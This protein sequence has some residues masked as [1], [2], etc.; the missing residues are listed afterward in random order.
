M[1]ATCATGVCACPSGQHA[2]GQQCV[3]D[4]AIMS[5]GTSCVSCPLPANGQATCQAS[6]CG[7]SCTPGFRPSGNTCV[8]V[9]EC[10]TG[11]GGCSANASC[12]NT[13]GARTCACRNG[14]TGDGVTCTDVD[15]CATSNGGCSADAT[16][17]NTPGA[18]T[19]ACRSGFTGDGL[20]C[21]DVN[22]C[23][24]NN[25]GCSTSA[26]CANTAGARTCTCINGFSGDGVTCTD[27]NE[28]VTNH[29]GCAA[30]ASGG[31]CTNTP[32]SRTCTC[33][34]GF[35]GDGLTCADINECATNNGGCS[36]NG[37]CTNTPG[38]RTCACLS[39]FSGD[40]LVC[41]DINECATNNGGC[42]AVASGGVCTNTLGSRTCACASG[43]AGN[44]L[45]C[46]DV[47]ECAT[48]NGGCAAVASG[49]VCTNT[50]GSRTC[51]CTTGYTGTGF[52]CSDIN[53]CLTANGGC[54][55]VGGV[56]TN[57]AGG[58][59]CAC[60]A[61]YAGNGLTCIPSG[62]RCTSP[63]PIG[64]GTSYGY[65]HARAADET[66]PRGGAC[67]GLPASQ[68]TGP[69][70]A[71]SFTPST[72]ERFHVAIAPVGDFS[73]LSF[74]LTSCAGACTAA[75][76]LSLRNEFEVAGVAGTP[77]VIVVKTN[78]PGAVAVTIT[79]DGISTPAGDTCATALPLTAGLARTVTVVS[80]GTDDT[81][82]TVSASCPDVGAP[83]HDI[84][85]SFTPSTSGLYAFS[86]TGTAYTSM[87][88]SAGTCGGACVAF[89]DGDVLSAN[90]TAG[91]TYYL[92][93]EPAFF[94]YDALTVRVDAVTAPA[95]DTC[96]APTVLPVST[97]VTSNATAAT[98][99]FTG[100]TGALCRGVN[101]GAKETFTVFTPPTTGNY[102]VVSAGGASA[103]VMSS[104]GDLSTC[105]G[106]VNDSDPVSLVFNGVA[107]VPV[108]LASV[109]Y[110]GSTST[111]I[112]VFPVTGP[113]NDTCATAEPL[114]L[115]T[116][117][118]KDISYAANDLAPNSA[119]CP[120]TQTIDP[121]LPDIVFSFTPAT[122]GPYVFRDMSVN[123]SPRL[124]LMEGS[125]GAS[126]CVEAPLGRYIQRTLQAGVTYY[127]GVEEGNG[128]V[129][130]VVD[131][132]PAPANDGCTNPTS[133][134]LNTSYSLPT[135]GATDTFN[136]PG[137]GACAMP[138][139]TTPDTTYVFTPNTS[140]RYQLMHSGRRA[141]VS[142]TC[143]NIATCQVASL[144]APT[145]SSSTASL[146]CPCSSP[147]RAPAGTRPRCRSSLRPRSLGR[148]LPR[149]LL[150][151]ADAA[152]GDERPHS[153]WSLRR[154]NGG[155]RDRLRVHSLD[156]G[157]L[158]LP[159]GHLES[160]RPL[161]FERHV[162]R[163]LV[164]RH[165]RRRRVTVV[166]AL[167]RPDHLRGDG[168]PLDVR[169]RR[170]GSAGGDPDS[171][172]HQR[173]KSGV[174]VR[175]GCVGVP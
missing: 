134:T 139:M 138:A 38:S 33:A 142:S 66:A 72:T 143:G 111:T 47:N 104:C 57:T 93:V 45:S 124:F 125:C 147:S 157:H 8:D 64:L 175:V 115:S 107:G 153:R 83:R 102:Y 159:R 82:A 103:I 24:T 145:G 52:T 161:G 55:A 88:L 12:T 58:R 100:S 28:C 49:G 122:T 118:T 23:A 75:D 3:S 89:A 94:V 37:T 121:Q 65:T 20:T 168:R 87:W 71:F 73:L 130:V 165:Q 29:G 116:P 173:T 105:I 79:A 41:N 19:C 169:W 148:Q 101:T 25:G 90:L 43:Y 112:R 63:I 68:L 48:N 42:A 14:F 18:R 95:N 76:S 10:A 92:S 1:G 156:R 163:G 16:C 152:R 135:I 67:A 53:E 126:A 150:R 9:D 129:T 99:Q 62:E 132:A 5:C 114:T 170:G 22:E 149:H 155:A 120:A 144:R 154:G 35:T 44:G 40:G 98:S 6:T 141:W 31:V 162:R 50:P 69:D 36:V 113:T 81:T 7:L 39:G 167:G 4:T 106:G 84:I 26:T 128:N 80:K 30:V 136:T 77:I 158:A 166:D 61:G 15:E 164:H 146:A 78:V 54:A 74:A 34:T 133:L 96:A 137:T 70:T 56:C 21:A 119:A 160:S 17:T 51:S 85:F 97:V 91:V 123:R 140:R 32:G 60:A 127:L 131:P 2:C 171:V 11:N 110:P 46:G 27:I 174:E 86:E 172:T 151:H 108:Y 109:G 13:V 117:V 59:S